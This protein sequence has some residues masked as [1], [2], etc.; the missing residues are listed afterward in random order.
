MVI[1][2]EKEIHPLAFK[3]RSIVLSRLREVL[4]NRNL[5]QLAK[6]LG[7][8]IRKAGHVN[9]GWVGQ[10]IERAAGLEIDNSK[11]P[12]GLDFELKTTT[13]ACRNNDYFPKETIKITQLNLSLILE[14]EFETSSLWSK[15]SRLII[16]GYQKIKAYDSRVV[17]ITEFDLTSNKLINEIRAFWEDVRYTICT[18]EMPDHPY[19]GRSNDY[20]QLRPTGTGRASSTCPVTGLKVPA[21]AFYATKKLVQRMLSDR[22]G[23]YI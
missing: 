1:V 22:S 19:L 11:R 7:I 21:Q 9:K 20:L 15:L 14:E 13:L 17:C 10:T 12:D 18:G 16:V 2:I 6:E 4:P 5:Y 3:S 23:F 8:T